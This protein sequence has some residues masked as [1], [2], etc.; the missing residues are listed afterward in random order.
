MSVLRAEL[1]AARTE[2]AELKALSEA[3][4]AVHGAVSLDVTTA[5]YFRGV[6][7]EDSGVIAQPGAELGW[8]LC[9]GESL[10]RDVD[11]TIGTWYST[12]GNST[13]GGSGGIC[14]END[15]YATLSARLF[16][17]VP[18]AASYAF[19]HSPNG[20]F[21]TV[22]EVSLSLGF[23]DA[24]LLL[25]SGLQPSVTFAFETNGQTDAGAKL[26][27]YVEIGVSPSVSLCTLADCAVT[28]ALPV[29]V[30]LGIHDYFELPGGGGDETFGFA[31]VGMVV[32]YD[33]PCVPARFGAWSMSLGLH[34]L[35]LGDSNEARN[36]GDSDEWVGTLGIRT[37]F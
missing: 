19:Y 5:Y 27:S 8:R 2:L 7:Q 17:R 1:D 37:T 13:T 6:L 32:S 12:H 4:P 31:D 14:Y 25:D 10:V 11:L 9:G 23:D 33:V 26:G 29:A 30:G 34:W 36:S 22:Q 35:G 24:G 21:R 15:A 3:R 20:S 18:A 16:E 28:L